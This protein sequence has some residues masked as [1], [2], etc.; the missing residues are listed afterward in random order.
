MLIDP[1]ISQLL[2]WVLQGGI[3]MNLK[4]LNEFLTGSQQ[5]GSLWAGPALSGILRGVETEAGTAWQAGGEHPAVVS[6][7]SSCSTWL[8]G[9]E[10]SP[11]W[12]RE[13]FTN[14]WISST[15]NSSTAQS[16]GICSS[17]SSF[18]S[19]PGG[20]CKQTWPNFPRY[21][22]PWSSSVPFER[23]TPGVCFAWFST[24]KTVFQRAVFPRGRAP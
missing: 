3:W 15:P 17:P 21:L 12:N 9:L 20:W 23:V 14:S 7:L 19:P 8:K 1:L 6:R 18:Q 22:Y 2:F 11:S 24:W 5:R 4:L 13:H 16:Q 10:N